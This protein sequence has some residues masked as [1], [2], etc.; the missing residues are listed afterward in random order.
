M[1][2]LG[3]NLPAL[4][5]LGISV[6]IGLLM[7][8][9]FRYTSDQK[10]IHIAKDHLKAHLLALRL[11][12]DQIPVVI[13]SYGRI[14]LATGRYL[15]LAFMP[16]LFVSVPLILLLAQ[17]DRY[18]GSIPFE[19]GRPFLV[20]ARFVSADVI[21]DA[22][23]ELPT[24]LET[25]A[26]AVHVPAENEVVWRLVAE[27]EG[28]FVVNVVTSAQTSAKRIVVGSGIP[29]LSALRLRGQFLQRLLYSAEPALP[30]GNLVQAIEVQYPSRDIAFAG[31]QWNWIWLFFVLSLAAGFLFKSILGIEI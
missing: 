29:R 14:L 21:G 16:L 31:L 23:L 20:S 12:Q 11:F 24:G 18:L 15:R 4:I 28:N 1:A 13:R 7:V 17:I 19:T 22:S 5:V 3:F 10:A 27:R 2:S 26:P 25:T 30:N 6:V 8:L 9:V